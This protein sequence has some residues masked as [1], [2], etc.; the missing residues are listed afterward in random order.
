MSKRSGNFEKIPKD[1]YPTTDPNAVAPL[2]PFIRCK[3]YAEPFYGEG[4]LED[5]LMDAATCR[6]RSDIRETVVASKVMPATDILKY[7]LWDCDVIISNPPFTKDVLLPCIDHLISL[8]PMWLL[9]PADMMH[10]KYFAPHMR[11]CSKVVSV[12]RIKWFK[13]SKSCSTD[14]FA[15]YYWKQH[16]DEETQTIFYSRS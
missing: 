7:D 4:D 1:F 13:G 15:W 9:L 6:W 8:K 16:A 3:T 12:G 10:N 11:M 14:N 5:L 2:V